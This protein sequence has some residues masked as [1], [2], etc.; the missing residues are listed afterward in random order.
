MAMD[1]APSQPTTASGTPGPLRTSDP[2]STTTTPIFTPA[3]VQN[4]KEVEVVDSPTS[5]ASPNALARFEFEA[6]RGNDGSKI[7]MVEWDPAPLGEDG[8]AV[9]WEGKATTFPVS[10][11]LAVDEDEG[12]VAGRNQ[13]RQRIYFLLPSSAT[14]PPMVTISH[15]GSGSGSGLGSGSGV[16]GATTLAA[17]SM[18]AIFAP[19]LG[20]GS[21][22][23]G[24]RGVLHTKWARLR[25][26][27][28]QDEIR[29][30][31]RDNSES[32][33]LE[34][35]VQERLWIIEH[36]GL[37]ELRPAAD[38]SAGVGLQN[39][40]GAAAASQQQQAP[41]SPRS[42]VSG[43]LG[44][45]LRG[46]KL[47]TSPSELVNPSGKFPFPPFFFCLPLFPYS[48]CDPLHS[49]PSIPTYIH[50]YINESISL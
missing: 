11:K 25:A 28:L 9:S 37:E 18:P 27:Q 41:Q 15:A 7:L 45:K 36:F 31:L 3:A 24:R 19:G 5:P 6:G 2:G 4:E 49:Y 44:E 29:A 42:P 30:E 13:R 22:E 50:K 38:A 21:R 40:G 39:A 8:W 23:A 46:L 35:A 48:L 20:I 47:A 33:A 1:S 43:R 32:V 12:E 17:K 14:I 26:A 16:H 34:M 10:E